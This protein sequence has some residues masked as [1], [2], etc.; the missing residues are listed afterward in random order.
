MRDTIQVIN[1]IEYKGWDELVLSHPDY[2][3]FHSSGWARVLSESYRYTPVYFTA[4]TEKRFSALLPVME[5]KSILTGTR[6]VSLPFTDYC[7][8]IMNGG[9]SFED[10]L[11]QVIGFGKKQNWKYIELR[12]GCR[13]DSAFTSHVSRLRSDASGSS[14]LGPQSFF[15][16]AQSPSLLPYGSYLGHVLGL[17]GNEEEVLN[18][19]RDSARRNIKKANKEGVGVEIFNSLDSV[20]EFYRLNCLTRRDHGLPPQPYGFFKNI[21]QHV[22]SKDHGFVV[23]ASYQGKYIAGAVF[24]HFGQK[25]LYKYGA[26][27]RFHQQ[28]RA[29]NLV[30]WE[31]I[32]WYCRKGYKSLCLG[33][34]EPENQGLI[35]FKSGLRPSGRRINYYRY[36]FKKGSFVSGSSKVV[37]FHNKIF[38]NIPIPV[39][40]QVGSILYRHMG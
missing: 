10:L 21:H 17:G 12:G 37:G 1:P 35:R 16:E 14:V 27:D 40:R 6:G 22:I 33:K 30:M 31:A 28:L 39:L 20:R 24:F 18:G 34:T 13:D 5:V 23:L 4:L 11:D 36:D 7:E 25:A 26:S 38:R 29:N 2:S 32:R 3:F 15:S 8:P 19:F 9:H